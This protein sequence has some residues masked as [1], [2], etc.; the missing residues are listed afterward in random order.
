[1]EQQNEQMLN[2]LRK[3]KESV[4]YFA[5]K[6]IAFPNTYIRNHVLYQLKQHET[7]IKQCQQE[8]KSL[9]LLHGR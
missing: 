2:E 5:S 8:N 3:C 4:T 9:L 6:Y 1:M 7:L